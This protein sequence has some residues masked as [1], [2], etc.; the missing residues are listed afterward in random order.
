MATELMQSRSTK[1]WR[2]QADCWATLS[3]TV[4]LFVEEIGAAKV[5]TKTAE[6]IW[7]EVADTLSGRVVFRAGCTRIPAIRDKA[8]FKRHVEFP[9][10]EQR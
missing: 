4:D 3:P 7:Y 1:V 6:A 8:L 10:L 9:L 2:T 5:L